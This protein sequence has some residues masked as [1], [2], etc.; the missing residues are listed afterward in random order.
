[1]AQAVSFFYCSVEHQIVAAVLLASLFV[2]FL[3]QMVERQGVAVVLRT[4]DLLR[5]FWLEKVLLVRDV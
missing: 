4:L 5:S 2:L 1:M 3:Q